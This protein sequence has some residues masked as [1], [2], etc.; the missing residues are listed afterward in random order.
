MVTKGAGGGRGAGQRDRR[1]CEM[2]SKVQDF[3][4][5]GDEG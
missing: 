4:V 5:N 1:R 2:G 3:S